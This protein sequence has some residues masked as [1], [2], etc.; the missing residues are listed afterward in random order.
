MT[1]NGLMVDELERIWNW[2]VMAQLRC[3]LKLSGH[4]AVEVQFGTEKSWR[5]W[6]TIST[7]MLNDWG[8]GRTPTN[9]SCPNGAATRHLWNTNLVRYR[10]AAVFGFCFS[11]S[12]STT[13]VLWCCH[14]KAQSAC[15]SAGRV[16]A[17]AHCTA[18]EQ[19]LCHRLTPGWSRVSIFSLPASA[20][21][22]VTSTV[23]QVS[24]AGDVTCSLS[25]MSLGSKLPLTVISRVMMPWF[26]M[27]SVAVR[28]V[29]FLTNSKLGNL[30]CR[31]PSQHLRAPVTAVGRHSLFTVLCTCQPH[32]VT[33][34]RVANLLLFKNK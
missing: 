11:L 34:Q 7:F 12:P 6:G 33:L 32:R 8:K 29:T 3:S 27:V 25:L 23:L 20:R 9:I 1:S 22:L 17:H 16:T 26:L 18:A 31:N 2:D 10:F 14:E 5:S 4:G 15:R 24:W 28:S 30:L 13:V 21:L 19:L